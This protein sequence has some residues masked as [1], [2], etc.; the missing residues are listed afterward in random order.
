MTRNKQ[1]NVVVV[2]LTNRN[3]EKN[4]LWGNVILSTSILQNAKDQ[5]TQNS[6]ASC[7]VWV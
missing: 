7:L 5:D 3:E 6:F 2:E 4:K 1:K